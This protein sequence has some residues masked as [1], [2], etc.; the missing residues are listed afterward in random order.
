M[1]MVSPNPLLLP[2]PREQTE[3][4]EEDNVSRAINIRR[5]RSL[6]AV[7]CGSARAQDSPRIGVKFCTLT[8]ELRKQHKLAA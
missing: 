3:N 7:A 1:Q 6:C 4:M 2:L 5:P 8:L